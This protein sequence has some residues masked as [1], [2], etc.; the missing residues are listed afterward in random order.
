MS[1][2]LRYAKSKMEAQEILNDSFLKVFIK[3]EKYNVEKSFKGWLRRILINTALD[4]YR[5]YSKHYYL[6]NI[7]SIP[8]V[9]DSNVD[10]Q[11]ELAYEDLLAIIQQL[12]PAYRT[13][14]NLYVIDGFKHEEIAEKLNISVG[15]SKSNL[16]KARENIRILIKKNDQESYA[17]FIG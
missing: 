12:S 15:T 7:N 4:N 8:D 11:A 6:Q 13:I 2:C 17:K 10:V 14:F 3:I 5:K 16:S 1:I 9:Q